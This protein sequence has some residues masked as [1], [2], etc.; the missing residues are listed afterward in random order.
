MLLLV[1]SGGAARVGGRMSAPRWLCGAH[2]SAM[3]GD[4]DHA[5]DAA[6]ETVAKRKP[7]STVSG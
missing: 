3:G 2:N 1:R 5:R 7:A 4:H 6:T